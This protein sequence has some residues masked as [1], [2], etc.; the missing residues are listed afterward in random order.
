MKCFIKYILLPVCFIFLS[1]GGTECDC[2]VPKKIENFY[3]VSLTPKANFKINS[4]TIWINGIVSSKVFDES[5]RDSIFSG[6]PI[7]DVISVYKFVSP[8]KDYNSTDAIDRFQLIDDING[9]DFFESCKNGTIIKSSILSSNGLFFKYRLGLI[10]KCLGSYTISFQN[11]KIQNFNRNI[12]IVENYPIGDFPNQI[13]FISCGK[14]SWRK[15]NESEREY[16]FN[17]TN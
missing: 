5:I 9:I 2:V 14:L 11:S 6:K 1:C 3:N 15:L 13:G 12:N 8:T 17:V 4:D 7:K 10:P 16:Y